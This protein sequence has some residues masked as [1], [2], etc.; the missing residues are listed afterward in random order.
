MAVESG[1]LCGSCL[2][3]AIRYRTPTPKLTPTLCHC[4]SCRKAAGAHAV[5]LF[6][7]DRERTVIEG[8]VAEFQS[9]ANVVRGFCGRCGS[10]LTYWH[11]D[12]P[13]D[14]SFTIATLDDPSRIAP[15]DHT[16]MADAA[17]WDVPSDGLP[18]FPRDRPS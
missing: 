11:A 4:A 1:E 15:V 13:A 8:Q 3:G 9:S 2:C 17:S 7:V 10:A 16:W 14:L 18:Q 6:T 5:G 12:W